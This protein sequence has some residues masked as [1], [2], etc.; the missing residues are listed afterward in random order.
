ME[1]SSVLR[2]F[3][4]MNHELRL[5]FLKLLINVPLR[6]ADQLLPE[7]SE[8][9]YPQTRMFKDFCDKLERVY[10]F[11]VLQGVFSKKDCKPDSNF[12]RLLRVT[13]KVVSRISESD[14]YYR[15]W[16]GLAFLL[17]HEEVKHLDLSPM[18]LLEL[19]RKQ[20]LFD[21]GFLPKNY[22]EAN[23][24]EFVEMALTDYLSNLADLQEED[25]R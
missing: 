14:R 18:Q 15:A 12:Q 9:E 25:W 1:E 3:Y 2:R 22:V 11:E 20:W 16:L 4:T 7:A 10:R 23:K 21:L 6:V 17:A 5:R 24:A 19:C 13:K 8:A